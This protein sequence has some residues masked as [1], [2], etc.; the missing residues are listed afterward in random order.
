MSA[1]AAV[2]AASFDVELQ[3]VDVARWATT[4]VVAVESTSCQV[5]RVEV[6]P[7]WGSSEPAVTSVVVSAVRVAWP[8]C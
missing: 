1:A 5:T 4:T 8:G 7:S 2:V 3:S 6:W